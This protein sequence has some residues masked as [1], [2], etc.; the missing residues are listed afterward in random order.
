MSGRSNNCISVSYWQSSL[1]CFQLLSQAI[2]GCLWDARPWSSTGT[3]YSWITQPS[4]QFFS[5]F[6]CIARFSLLSGRIA[7]TLQWGW[8]KTLEL[9]HEPS[10]CFYI[11]FKWSRLD[12]NLFHMEGKKKAAV[13][14]SLLPIPKVPL[15]KRRRFSF[16]SQHPCQSSAWLIP[17][18]LLRD[19]T[20]HRVLL[21]PCSDHGHASSS[22]SCWCTM[23]DSWG[24]PPLR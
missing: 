15:A 16:V 21:H 5:S 1:C 11:L 13:P 7:K 6:L 8:R 22:L 19:P 12:K 4:L 3:F 18:N 10:G 2:P 17:F 24:I 9:K 20:G 23:V 14:R